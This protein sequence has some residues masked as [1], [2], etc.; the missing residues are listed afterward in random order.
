MQDEN[1]KITDFFSFYSLESSIINNPKHK[2]LRVAYLFYYATEVGLATPV[3]KKAHKI[4]LNSL[5]GD[6]LVL[7]K[8]DKFDVF[9][10]LSIMDNGLFLENQKFG[11]GD[12]QLNYYLFNYR[13]NSIA[14]GV[15]KRNQLDEENLSG[16]GFAML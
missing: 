5:V 7:A 15:N 2:V 14:G 1:Q 16:I 12:G 3:D 8:K 13:A 6:A 11:P 9:N 4:R 10:A